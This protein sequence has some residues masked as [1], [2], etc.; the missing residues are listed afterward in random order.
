MKLSIW[1]RDIVPQFCSL[2]K[3]D[4]SNKSLLHCGDVEDNESGD[5]YW[6]PFKPPICCRT[7][8][9]CEQK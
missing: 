2:S 9:L 7:K 4:G 6:E 3:S 5:P 1:N 8:L